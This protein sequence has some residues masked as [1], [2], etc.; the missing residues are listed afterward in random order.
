MKDAH[1][2]EYDTDTRDDT[3]DN[4]VENGLGSYTS[5]KRVVRALLRDPLPTNPEGTKWALNEYERL[6]RESGSPRDI[7][8]F[9]KI[10]AKFDANNIAYDRNTI[11]R[12][13]NDIMRDAVDKPTQVLIKLP[14]HGLRDK[15]K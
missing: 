3:D 14:D 4:T 7:E 6:I 13:R 2:H 11:Q 9:A 1:G 5:G 12:E 8:R 15:I 10:I